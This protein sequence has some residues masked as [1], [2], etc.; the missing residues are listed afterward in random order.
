MVSSNLP[1][2]FGRWGDG[3]YQYNGYFDEIRISDIARY[4]ENFTPQTEP[5]DDVYGE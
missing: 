5:F 2:R 1:I 4:T 3:N